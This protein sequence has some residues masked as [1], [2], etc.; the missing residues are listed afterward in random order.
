MIRMLF[1]LIVVGLTFAFM[2]KLL[3]QVE[4]PDQATPAQTAQQTIEDAERLKAL[5]EK[6]QQATETRVEAARRE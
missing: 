3:Q 1:A 6:Q 2:A 4:T 5:L